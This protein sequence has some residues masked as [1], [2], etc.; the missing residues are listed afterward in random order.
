MEI[1][2]EQFHSYVTVQKSGLTNMFAVQTV[3]D[4]SGLT[5][6]EVFAIQEQYAA[7]LDQYGIP[8]EVLDDADELRAE[9]E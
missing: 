6:E 2:Q 3:C 9:F 8:D 1:T 4:L 5:R 7:L